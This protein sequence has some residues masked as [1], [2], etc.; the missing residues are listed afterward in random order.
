MNGICC[1]VSVPTNNDT[2]GLTLSAYP[3]GI[4]RE[5]EQ[6]HLMLLHVPHVD[7]ISGYLTFQGLLVLVA[8]DKHL[9][10]EGLAVASYVPDASI[11]RWHGTPTQHLKATTML[12]KIPG[13]QTY[14]DVHRTGVVWC[15][16]NTTRGIK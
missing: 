3:P 14:A 2:M 4:S 6:S 9:P 5:S 1:S 12:V 13:R 15:V 8:G 11:V 16:R 7:T 10:H